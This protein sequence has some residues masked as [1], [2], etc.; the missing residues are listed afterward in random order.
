VGT[1]DEGRAEGTSLVEVEVEVESAIGIG[2]ALSVATGGR[3]FR[4]VGSVIE[5]AGG[6]GCVA[7]IR[8]V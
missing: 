2:G 1:R 8:R 6:A 3:S 4:P 5:S 7:C